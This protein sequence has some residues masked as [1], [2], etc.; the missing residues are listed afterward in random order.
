M[1]RGRIFIN[2]RRDDSR[3]DSGRLHDRLA[4]RFPGKVFRDVA[5]LEPGVEW[6]EAIARVLGQ[7]DA[8]I[9]VIGKDWLNITDAAGRRRLDSPH[10][11]VRQEIVTAL[12]RKMR[13]F[14]VLVG[15][16]KMPA[17]EELLPDLQPLCRR[18]AWEITE[19]AWDENFNRLLQALERSLGLRSKRLD[20]SM[21]STRTKWI[22][23]AMGSVA[24]LA[25]L[26]TYVAGNNH[27]PPSDT[28]RQPVSGAPARYASS[29]PQ[30]HP[31]A[32]PASAPEPPPRPILTAGH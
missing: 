3:A 20:G 16:A 26:A 28:S 11:T 1:A 13:V 17:D 30:E 6:H 27:A 23:A 8:C 24:M 29:P 22:L 18:N 31:A 32:Q 5:S 21:F 7:A 2:Y 10:D 14:P 25:V 12:A 15:G 9:V 19:Q 4:L